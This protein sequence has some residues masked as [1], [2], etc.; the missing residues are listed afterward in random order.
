MKYPKLPSF[1]LDGKSALI[2]GAGRGIGMGASI[3]LAESGA[4]VTLVSRTEK[5]LK[6]LTEHIK[7]LGFKANYEVLDVN[8]ENEVSKLIEKS[9]AFDILINNAGTNK[10]AKLIDTNIN[11]FDHVMSLNVRSVIYL[12]KHVV[13]KML[14]NNIKG[15]IINV[16]SQMGHV[17]GPNRTTYCA[18]KFAIEGF[19]KALAIE[20][21]PNQI[22]VNTVCPT[23]IQT[24]MTEPFLKDDEFKKTTIGMIPLGRLGEVKDLM[25]PFVFLASEASSLMTGSS[26]LVDGGWTAR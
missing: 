14:D 15:S 6:E 9:N 11:D 17:G 2:T 13:K 3:A 5:E 12:T 4:N 1:R 18:S 24:P 21:G 19:T 26:L 16:S 22:R 25:G 7:S 20:L 10:P 8:D 23:F